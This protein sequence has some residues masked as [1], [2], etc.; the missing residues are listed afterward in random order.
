M[1][2]MSGWLMFKQ[3]ILKK[4]KKAN[5]FGE[6]IPTWPVSSCKCDATEHGVGKRCTRH[7]LLAGIRQ[8]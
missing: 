6:N 3:L 7:L 4:K 1:G 5:L 2:L 8:L